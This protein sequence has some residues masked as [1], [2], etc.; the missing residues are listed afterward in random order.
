MPEISG[1][2]DH[3]ILRKS[4]HE[5]LRYPV[6]WDQ[7]AWKMCQR[8]RVST[9]QSVQTFNNFSWS[10]TSIAALWDGDASWDAGAAVDHG[11]HTDVVL[12]WRDEDI[13]L[14]LP[15]ILPRGPVLLFLR[16]LN[17][18]TLD[19]HRGCWARNLLQTRWSW[20]LSYDYAMVTNI[21]CWTNSLE[22]TKAQLD[23]YYGQTVA[24][25]SS[26]HP[27]SP[28]HLKE[29]YKDYLLMHGGPIK[30]STRA[31]R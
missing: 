4:V 15:S 24:L 1:L 28:E 12:S 20:R 22:S 7:H 25:F 10:L 8:R 5:F 21:H 18:V 23:G 30:A 17:N 27:R 6:D 31:R 9:S 26:I 14:R 3:H 29:V 11:F 16:P 19:V 2:I 13:C